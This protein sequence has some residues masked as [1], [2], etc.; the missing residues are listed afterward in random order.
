MHQSFKVLLKFYEP[1]ARQNHKK[2]I[3][4][5]SLAPE[6]LIL[7]GGKNPVAAVLPTALSPWKNQ[8]RM[9]SH[10]NLTYSHS[11]LIYS[12]QATEQKNLLDSWRTQLR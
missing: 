10:S 11:D 1:W 6:H 4:F 9:D 8:L 2:G 7:L 12:S 5:N 3:S